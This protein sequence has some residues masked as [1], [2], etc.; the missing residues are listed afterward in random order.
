LPP[1]PAAA[2]DLEPVRGTGHGYELYTLL[3]IKYGHGV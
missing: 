2:A 1:F 3:I